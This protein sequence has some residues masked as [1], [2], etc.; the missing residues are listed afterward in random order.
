[1]YIFRYGIESD[2]LVAKPVVISKR[3]FVEA[4][5][6][7]NAD[8]AVNIPWSDGSRAHAGADYLLTNGLQ[9][10]VTSVFRGDSLTI[11]TKVNVQL[12]Y[13]DEENS[14]LDKTTLRAHWLR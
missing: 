12:R 6:G 9:G 3:D 10:T 2:C 4:D 11:A 1:M 8:L 7:V 5:G 13:V 14:R